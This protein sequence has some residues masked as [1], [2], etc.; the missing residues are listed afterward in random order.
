MWQR[1]ANLPWYGRL[2]VKSLLLGLIVMLCLFP[3]VDIF[4][5]QLGSLS[6]P[7]R[8]IQPDLPELT[9]INVRIDARLPAN[10]SEKDELRA[11]QNYVLAT[12]PYDYDWNNW[13]NIDYWPTARDVLARGRE[14]C[15][16]RAVLAAS[17][18]QSRGYTNA[19]VVGNLNHIWVNVGKRSIMGAGDKASLIGK[20]GKV[21]LELPT[22]R[23]VLMGIAFIAE[24]PP[25]R[26]AIILLSALA[27]AYH[28]CRHRLGFL[29]ISLGGIAGLALLIQ[30]GGPFLR[31]KTDLGNFQ[32]IGGC[33]LCLGSLLAALYVPYQILGRT[34]REVQARKITGESAKMAPEPG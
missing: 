7:K 9:E 15:D 17:I 26:S 6:D 20:S 11:V 8:L 14:D 3:R 32:F 25:L 16:G 4:V 23:N 19:T 33:F 30:W 10:A 29:L 24:F 22:K 21:K 12:I 31:A 28:P 34:R 18:L 27:L 5:K 13:G 2:T 1:L